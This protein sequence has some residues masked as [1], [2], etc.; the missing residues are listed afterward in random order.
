M[1][2]MSMKIN[3]CPS[4]D[5]MAAI[6]ALLNVWQDANPGLMVAMVP[7]GDCYKYEIIKSGRACKC[8][9]NNDA[10]STEGENHA[11]KAGNQF[12]RADTQ[13]RSTETPEA[14]AGPVGSI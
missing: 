6:L 1:D 2:E 11:N 7:A 13:E 8:G 12:R 4:E 14:D 10:R 9:A 5:S 3:L